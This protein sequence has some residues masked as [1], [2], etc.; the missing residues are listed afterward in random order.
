MSLASIIKD[1][2]AVL[3]Y[4]INWASDDGTND[5]TSSDTGWLQSDTIATSTWT[6]SG[7]DATL[8]E[9]SESESTAIATIVLSGGTSN[10]DYIVTN[11]IVTAAGYEDDRSLVVKVRER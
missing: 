11:H 3:P 7:S 2:D 1:P 5:G 8:V 4:S 9:D 6:I 10:R